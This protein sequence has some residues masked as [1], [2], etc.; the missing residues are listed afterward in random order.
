MEEG[1]EMGGDKPAPAVKKETPVEKQVIVLFAVL[2]IIFVSFL[3]SYQYFKPSNSF[4]YHDFT[5]YK[6]KLEGTTVDFYILPLKIGDKAPTNLMI[7]NDP[8]EIE[9]MTFEV[10][11]SFWRGM[12]GL[13]ITTDVNY[14]S[15][16]TIAA[17]EIGSFVGLIGVEADYGFTTEIGGYPTITCADATNVTKVIDIRLGNE[18]K[19]YSEGDCMIVEGVDYDSMIKASDKVVITWLERIYTAVEVNK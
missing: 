7:R 19:V 15:L 5:V 10:N 11:E 9:N 3:V 16:A 2:A 8:R 4:K 18:T 14:T 1:K 13:L 12:R 17:G 6:Q